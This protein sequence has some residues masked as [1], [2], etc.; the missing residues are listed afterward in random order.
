MSLVQAKGNKDD[1]SAQ[2]VQDEASL[3]PAAPRAGL[4]MAPRPQI[5][6][7]HSS[8]GVAATIRPPEVRM[9]AI[10][11]EWLSWDEYSDKSER[12][13]TLQRKYSQIRCAPGTTDDIYCGGL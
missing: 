12:E 5:G 9:T 1:R 3:S 2:A 11:R 4:S 8:R 13:G 10:T 6:N 7:V